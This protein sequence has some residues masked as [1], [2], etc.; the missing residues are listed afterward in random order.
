MIN[1]EKQIERE[2]QC[3]FN[4]AKTQ[5]CPPE[6]KENLYNKL[7]LK[8]SSFSPKLIAAGVSMVF[9]ASITF[10][11]S[12]NKLENKGNQHEI[13]KAHAELQVAIHYINRVSLKS[14]TAVNNKGIK[15][16][17]IKPL[18]KTSILM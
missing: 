14:L 17:I 11:I 13:D 4:N 9:I 5:K 6:M 7:N 16:A 2:L 1:K 15:P 12:T 18:A 8:N 3:Y 10:K